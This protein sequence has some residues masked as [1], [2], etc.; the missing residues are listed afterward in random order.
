MFDILRQFQSSVEYW[1][2]DINSPGHWTWAPLY[3]RRGSHWKQR[4]KFLPKQTFKKFFALLWTR[5]FYLACRELAAEGKCPG[6]RSRSTVTDQANGSTDDWKWKWIS[7]WK[8]QCHYHIKVKVIMKGKVKVPRSKIKN[9]SH[10]P[11]KWVHWWLKVKINMI[12][13]GKVSGSRSTVTDQANGSTDDW[14]WI[15]RSK[16]KWKLP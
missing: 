7:R 6:A 14:K 15:E 3:R 5:N 9:H 16:W 8:W 4:S 11:G 2:G 13:K 12:M 1:G 10:R